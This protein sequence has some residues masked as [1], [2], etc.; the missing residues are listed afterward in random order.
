MKNLK[1]TYIFIALF[2]MAS[3]SDDFVDV[4]SNAENSEDF[5]NSE[6]DYQQALIAAY[7]LLQTTYQSVLLGEIASDNTLCGGENANDVPG[8]QEVDDMIHTPI[9][10]QL[11]SI[12]QWMYAGVNR[13]NYI[14]EFQDKTDFE[15]KAG[16]LAQTRF[17]RAYYYFELVKWFGDVPFAVDTRLQFGDQFVVG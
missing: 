15:G 4:K 2:V 9:N 12:W 6:D 5:F 7:D 11:R 14:M 10:Q 16:V 13:A 3:C 1:I 8:F 17:L